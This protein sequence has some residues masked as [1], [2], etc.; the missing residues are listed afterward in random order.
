MKN[1]AGKEGHVLVSEIRCQTRPISEK[2]GGKVGK[3][4]GSSPWELWSNPCGARLAPKPLLLAA[5]GGSGAPAS[6]SLNC[7]EKEGHVLIE[8]H[9]V[10][11]ASG[12][13][14]V[15]P[16]GVVLEPNL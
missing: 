8:V 15:D 12:A 16:V 11:V 7:E 10:E 9:I 3:E 5:R 6:H 4:A 2:V 14:L 13:A 1:Y